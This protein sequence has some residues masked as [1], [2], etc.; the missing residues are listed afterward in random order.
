M[1]LLD[2][3][4]AIGLT[5]YEAKTYLALLREHPATG[6]QISKNSGVPR[7]MVYEV[8]GRLRSR[9]AV[10]E[11]IEGRTTLYR[12][13]DPEILLAE[14]QESIQ[15]IISDLRPGLTELFQNKEDHKVWGISGMESIF[16]YAKK[17]LQQTEKEAFLVLN[18]FHYG[19]LKITLERLAE[20]GIEQH[21]LATGQAP[22]EHGN[23][24]Y[25]PPLESE[26][27]GLTD[28]LLVLVDQSEVLIANTSDEAKATITSNPNLIMIARQFI[29]MEFFT[30]RIYAQIGDELLAKLDPA[31]R[32]IF[33]SIVHYQKT[34]K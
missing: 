22:I 24:V 7:S 6:Y 14:H 28:T 9:G 15:T 16:S 25:H 19:T 3:L 5:E 11:S 10:L 34:E 13:L 2:N 20:T 23:L 12:P 26:I 31:D 8:L 27:Q 1:T 18:D 29:W 32:E 21:I 4:Q 33:N 30:Q 17:M